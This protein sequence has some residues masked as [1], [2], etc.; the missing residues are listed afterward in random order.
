MMGPIFE[1]YWECWCMTSPQDYASHFVELEYGPPGSGHLNVVNIAFADYTFTRDRHDQLNIGFINSQ[2][3]RDGLPYTQDRLSRDI[4]SVHSQGG[5]VKLSFGGATFPMHRAVSAVADFT[6]KAVEAVHQFGLDGL[7]IDI[8]DRDTSADSQIDVFTR[9]RAALPDKLISYTVPA[10]AHKVPMYHQVLMTAGSTLSSLNVMAYDVY[11]SDY[12]PLVDFQ[13]FV[14]LGIPMSRIVWGVM[15]GFSDCPS[16]FTSVDDARHIAGLVKAH[17][18]GGVMMW[19]LN[20]DTNH[21][22]TQ[23]RQSQT[24]LPDATFTQV[25]ASALAR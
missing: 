13:A 2:V 5:K 1:A 14:A 8:E 25:F 4:A 16:E 22:A 10:V 9:L 19:S 11:W 23:T 6:S 7:D 15:P 18:L 24:G 12:Q 21:R 20:R 17:G 3:A